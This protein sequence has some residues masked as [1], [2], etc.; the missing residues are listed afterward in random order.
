[1]GS[2]R[3]IFALAARNLSR[4]RRRSLITLLAVFLAVSI[5][6]IVR[7][8]LNALLSS[9]EE[10]IID[11]D[12]GAIQIHRKGF[13]RSIQTS[14]LDLDLSAEP[15]FLNRIRSMPHVKAVAARIPFGAMVNA[16]DQTVFARFLGLDPVEETKVCKMKFQRVVTGHPLQS[17]APSGGNLSR[18]LLQRVKSGVGQSV[19]VLS[20]DRDGVMN[21]LDVHVLGSMPDVG[22]MAMERKIG[23]LPLSLSQA[24]LRM[25]G[26][27]TEI[28]VGVDDRKQIDAVAGR[29]RTELGAEFEVSTWR[30]LVP[31]VEEVM[32]SQDT[33]VVWVANIF[34]LVALI[35]IANTMQMNVRE[36]T[37]EIGTM[38][39]VGVRRYQIIQL[40]TCEAVWI[41]I[42]GGLLGVVFGGVVVAT[43]GSV[44][45]KLRATGG[46]SVMEL[47]PFVSWLHLVRTF[48][49][50]A[51]GSG[52]A[53]FY[54]AW[55]ASRLRPVEALAR[56]A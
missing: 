41:G 13:L 24:L 32:Q 1:M 45:I 10:E 43:L 18:L 47:R 39:A 44:G 38:M 11:G 52:V 23:W 29:L 28:A 30:E 54:P 46:T 26:R 7:G 36:R 9:V 53:A 27:A 34:L 20:N 6:V 5:V 31:E 16:N 50:A 35:G 21:A 3:S 2:V 37:R 48:F 17:S 55:R 56:V 49:V 19:A 33:A 15:T 14:P 8:G 12:V 51:V 25:P 40:F 4:N 22:M 42:F